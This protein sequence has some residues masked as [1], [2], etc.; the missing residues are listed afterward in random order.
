MLI[1]FDNVFPLILC[2]FFAENNSATEPDNENNPAEL[3]KQILSRLES[4]TSNTRYNNL[5]HILQCQ[6]TTGQ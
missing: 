1:N 4:I 6:P 5:A 3:Q 2:T